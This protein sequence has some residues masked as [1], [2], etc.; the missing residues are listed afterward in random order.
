[1]CYAAERICYAFA[2]VNSAEF[3]AS[4]ACYGF[5]FASS[6][7]PAVERVADQDLARE[8]TLPKCILEATQTMLWPGLDRS[9]GERT[10]VRVRDCIA[11]A[12]QAERNCLSPAPA[13][14]DLGW[15]TQARPRQ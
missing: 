13:R 12:A 6:L 1:M 9:S 14:G 2:T 3:R 5:D 8:K 15:P 11:G 7:Q 4:Y 10:F